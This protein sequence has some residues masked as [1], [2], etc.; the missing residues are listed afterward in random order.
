MERGEE[1]VPLVLQ[2][3]QRAQLAEDTDG[4][5]N[6]EAYDTTSSYI[7]STTSSDVYGTTGSNIYD[8]TGTDLFSN[9]SSYPYSTTGTDVY[10]TN[11]SGITEVAY[12]R[13]FIAVIWISQ[14]LLLSFD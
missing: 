14:T 8:T 10:G 6:T 7:Y 13:D 12:K 11:S 5:Q 3:S 1:S 4:Y 2:L 9:G